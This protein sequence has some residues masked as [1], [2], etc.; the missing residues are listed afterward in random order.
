[1][2]GVVRAP[3]FPVGLE[4]IHT[5]GPLTLKGLRG[6]WVLL[7]F[8]TYC[9]VNCQ[10]VSAE[11]ARLEDEFELVVIGVHAGK[12]TRELDTAAIAE[13]VARMGVRH[14]VVNDARRE[15]WDQYAVRAWPTLVLIDPAGRVMW[16]KAGEGAYEP[17]SAILDAAGVRRAVV[18]EREAA[19]TVAG[20][21]YPGKIAVDGASGRMFVADSGQDRVVVMD[22]QGRVERVIG[23]L[24]NPQGMA[25]HKGRLYVADTGNHCVRVV[26]LDRGVVETIGGGMRSPWDVAWMDGA[27]Y[28]AMAGTHQIWRYGAGGGEVFAGAGGENLVDGPRR[29]A[30]LAQP[31]GIAAGRGE[32]YFVDSEASAVRRVDEERVETLV[33]TGLFAFGDV[34]GP[35]EQALLAHPLGVALRGEEVWVA[36]SYNGKVKRIVDGRVETMVS[37]LG[38]PGGLVWHG[39]KLYV[40]DTNRHRIVV[41]EPESGEV[42]ELGIEWG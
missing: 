15:V 35:V 31:S 5:P 34:D 19:V 38:E 2:M 4:W 16:T 6:R 18:V 22:G 23:G 21:R 12:F 3:E 14:A 39:G 8:W 29:E 27:L 28:I 40:A 11:V 42:V 25:W 32:L 30:I 9:C 33:G 1:M 24:K 10:H 26:E 13:A 41:W 36:D 37:G 17:V 7:D 20:L